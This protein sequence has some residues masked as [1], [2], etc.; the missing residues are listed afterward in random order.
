MK[1]G[2]KHWTSPSPNYFIQ[3]FLSTFWHLS[4]LRCCISMFSE[5]II[6]SYRHGL[7]TVMPSEAGKPEP[8]MTVWGHRVSDR[9][10]FIDTGTCQEKQKQRYARSI[11]FLEPDEYCR[12]SELASTTFTLTKVSRVWTRFLERYHVVTTKSF[13]PSNLCVNGSEKLD[14]ATQTL[15][16]KF[17]QYLF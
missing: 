7:Y 17:L 14:C 2:V 5:L 1:N 4:P 11:R 15:V 16:C 6:P 12:R 3:C 8:K 13:S 9:H 10:P